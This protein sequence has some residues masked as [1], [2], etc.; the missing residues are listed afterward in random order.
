[1]S[2]AQR[3][4]NNKTLVVLTGPMAAGKGT[5]E[6][7][8]EARSIPFVSM[9]EL[10]EEQAGQPKE[11]IGREGMQDFANAQRRAHGPDVYARKAAEHLD[12]N[13]GSLAIIDGMRNIHEC[14]YFHAH[15]R[16]I[17]IGI[18]PESPD[19]EF[20]KVKERGRPGDPQT[21]EQFEQVRQRELGHGESEE[22]QQVAACLDVADAVIVHAGGEGDHEALVQRFEAILS[23]RGINWER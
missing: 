14:E 3:P 18:V 22:G 21:K 2:A 4:T 8:A 11:E 10:I 16:T 13:E 23:E 5:L 6:K 15:Y 12:T 9:S 20:E 17:V 7:W 19:Q 1:V